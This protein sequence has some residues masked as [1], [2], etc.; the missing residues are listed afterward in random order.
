MKKT[1]VAVVI[2]LGL[3]KAL[4]GQEVELP[5]ELPIVVVKGKDRSYLHIIRPKILARMGH[6]GE[7]E[8]SFPPREA[9]GNK[10]YHQ[11][12]SMPGLQVKPSPIIPWVK[13]KGPS[14]P[15]LGHVSLSTPIF[16]HAYAPPSYRPISVMLPASGTKMPLDIKAPT[17]L[18]SSV[19]VPGKG[20]KLSLPKE[21]VLLERSF[22]SSKEESSLPYLHFSASAGSHSNYGYRMD[23]GRKPEKNA[24]VFTLGR[25]YSPRR[26]EYYEEELSRD[27]DMAAIEFTRDSGEGGRILLGLGGHQIK[28]DM[29]D[30]TQRVK[31]KI[32]IEG[33]RKIQGKRS[34]FRIQGWAERTQIKI[35]DEVEYEDVAIGTR[36]SL[37]MLRSP[38][39]G[40]L[41]GETSTSSG[42]TQAYLFLAGHNV[43]LKDIKGLALNIEAGLK[44]IGGWGTEFVPQVELA[45]DITPRLKIRLNGQREFRLARF[46][47]LYFGR[48]YVIID[49]DLP[50]LRSWGFGGGFTYSPSEIW[51]ISLVGFLDRGDN[52]VWNWDGASS[53][54]RPLIRDILLKGGRLSWVL[55][56]ND[57]FEQELGYTYQEVDNQD[58]PGRIVPGYPGSSGELWLRWK[59]GNWLIEAGGEIEGERYYEEDLE[60][61]LP[62][63]YKGKVKVGR[64]IGKGGECW[65]ELQLNDYSPLENFS[66]PDRKVSVGIHIPLF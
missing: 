63:G 62:F 52:L 37:Q 56:L 15:R 49:E 32:D 10:S 58:N 60:K 48:D 64:K 51:D 40:G 11:P 5:T 14:P 30:G 23:Y 7:K 22:P 44:D 41:Q 16:Q 34:K 42:S 39:V 38:L 50:P 43:T 31:N 35:Q 20:A 8:L 4:W 18:P 46:S 6:R 66:L 19:M 33:E 29:P 55:H 25:D 2:L 53:L 59:P 27:E 17:I 36:I 45:Y 47:D 3:C 26:V 24:W 12:P 1:I 13:S 57:V 21:S 61:L 65:I 9:W 54:I 28:L